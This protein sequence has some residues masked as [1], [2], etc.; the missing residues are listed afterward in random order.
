M[1]EARCKER[2]LYAKQEKGFSYEELGQK[3]GRNKVW[4]AA[5]IQGQASMDEEEA[6]V[7]TKTLD[8]Q[9]DEIVSYLTS[10]PT[11]GSIDKDV[12]VD[13]LIYRFHEITQVY[14]TT[15]KEIIHEEFGDG[16]MSAIDFTMDVEKKEDPN[17]DRV[18]VTMD[19]KFLPYKKW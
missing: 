17:G 8:L 7:L 5:A 16:I 2:I 1:D 11:K 10:I 18:I 12:P 3:V 6:N 4:V 9:E 15:L 19:G 14:G 13:P